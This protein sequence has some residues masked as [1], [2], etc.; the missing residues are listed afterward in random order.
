[1]ASV[2]L[3]AKPL[4]MGTK[5]PDCYLR[6]AQVSGKCRP[7]FDH[8]AVSEAVKKAV[9]A[10]RRLRKRPGPSRR[11]ISPGVVQPPGPATA[12]AACHILEFEAPKIGE[13]VP[14]HAL[15][16]LTLFN[17][18]YCA[19]DSATP[20]RFDLPGIRVP[21]AVRSAGCPELHPPAADQGPWTP[22]PGNLSPIWPMEAL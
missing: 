16:I 7:W 22:G 12:H 4:I 14:L 13:R 2:A 11:Q 10:G 8:N 6:Q 18:R 15:P 5:W 19:H 20:I 17:L 21:R 9:A 3:S 1:M